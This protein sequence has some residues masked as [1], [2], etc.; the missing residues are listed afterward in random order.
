MNV[1]DYILASYDN[2]VYNWS[3]LATH[4]AER[5]F[6]LLMVIN[7]SWSAV[8][9]MFKKDDPM[10]LLMEFIQKLVALAFFLMIIEHFDTWIPA[11]Y[12]SFRQAGQYLTGV[13]ELNPSDI[14]SQGVHLSSMIMN[15][16]HKGGLLEQIGGALF[17]VIVALL[18]FLSFLGVGIQMTLII[19]G[20]K[21]ILAG[22]MVMLGFSGSKLTMDYA[23]RYF[24]AAV[25]I[26]LKLMFLMLI[27]GLGQDLSPS[28][29]SLIQNAP[30][31]KLL[32]SF[33]AVLASSLLF[34]FL[35]WKIPEMGASLLSGSLAMNL[36][37]ELGSYATATGLLASRGARIIGSTGMAVGKGLA[38]AA[39]ALWQAG[40]AGKAAALASGAT[41]FKRAGIAIGTSIKTLGSAS[42]AYMKEQFSKTTGGRIA[43][44]IRILSAA[45]TPKKEGQDDQSS[46]TRK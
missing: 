35:S 34:F 26:G 22:G 13:N 5:L 41:G 31:D 29:A 10:S 24:G 40:R 4:I 44:Q 42:G 21:I 3:I 9:W 25:H 46:A 7:L 6:M 19:V 1:F 39:P 18:V 15:V 43:N 20:G 8:V 28:W 11:I 27:T 38:G 12:Q 33:L 36:G 37:G 32:E 2:S 45:Q 23:Q 30:P 14:V 17:N 16:S